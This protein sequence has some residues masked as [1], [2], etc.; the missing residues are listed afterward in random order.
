M[1]GTLMGLVRDTVIDRFGEDFWMSLA[2]PCGTASDA[3]PSD[4]LACWAGKESVPRLRDAYPSLFDRHADLES[5]V[6]GLG[7]DLPAVRVEEAAH[8]PVS[9]RCGSSP[10]G[11]IL[12]RVEAECGLCALIEGVLA[13]AAVHYGE[14]ARIRELKSPRR[15]D[16]ACVVQIELLA[17]AGDAALP[18]ARAIQ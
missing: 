6:R 17:T 2:T 5:F 8:V 7:D 4:A 10:D 3:S 9:F 12:L 18:A 16:N 13:G 1:D 11:S 14:P 15:G